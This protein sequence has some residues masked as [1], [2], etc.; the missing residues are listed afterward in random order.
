VI[1]SCKV[2]GAIAAQASHVDGARLVQQRLKYLIFEVL[3][4]LRLQ[5]RMLF[6]N[7]ALYFSCLLDQISGLFFVFG[8]PK[9]LLTKVLNSGYERHPRLLV[10]SSQHPHELLVDVEQNTLFPLGEPKEDT[11]QEQHIH[12]YFTQRV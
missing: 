6:K 2:L 7:C 4:L 1:D 10:S 5:F 3:C 12:H 9:Q 8:E 11:A